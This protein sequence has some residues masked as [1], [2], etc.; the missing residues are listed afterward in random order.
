V[1][2]PPPTEKPRSL[3]KRVEALQ[4]RNI[5]RNWT[6]IEAPV[7][8]DSKTVTDY[9]A[10]RT[11]KQQAARQEKVDYHSR[12]IEKNPTAQ[13]VR[14]FITAFTYRGI[15]C[16][17]E[18]ETD[19]KSGKVI[20]GHWRWGDPEDSFYPRSNASEPL[21]FAVDTWRA[22]SN[23]ARRTMSEDIFREQ[24]GESGL[25]CEHGKTWLETCA[26]CGLI[27]NG[28]DPIDLDFKDART[29]KRG[30]TASANRVLAKAGVS[31]WAGK[32]EKESYAGGSGK[33]ADIDAAGQATKLIGGKRVKPKGIGADSD[34]AHYE[35]K[36]GGSQDNSVEGD[37]AGKRS[38]EQLGLN[39]TE[40]QVI[41]SYRKELKAEAAARLRD[42]ES[43]TY[44]TK[45]EIRKYQRKLSV[46]VKELV[47]LFAENRA[48]Q[49]KAIAVEKKTVTGRVKAEDV[50]ADTRPTPKIGDKLLDVAKVSV[51]THDG[52][53]PLVSQIDLPEVDED[54]SDG[55]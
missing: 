26:A 7:A 1:F 31:L 38:L 30:N 46:E 10:D 44:R 13:Q 4:S 54:S 21:Q 15:E 5:G 11:A 3:G 6:D 27:E 52:K 50:S 25:F 33:L 53:N 49:S 22:Y 18:Q 9:L 28:V 39:L 8:G 29:V 45:T 19:L 34:A 51:D 42:F 24:Y 43:E 17:V 32:S 2:V 36:A 37:H 20:E 23:K 35:D 48:K 40:K 16:W 41:T 55:E 47:R 12:F 14:D